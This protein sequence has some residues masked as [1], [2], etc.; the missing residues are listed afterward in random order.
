MLTL[1]AIIVERFGLVWTAYKARASG[2]DVMRCKQH[3]T[4]ACLD[5][6]IHPP[7]TFLS[8]PDVCLP[9]FLTI[10]DSTLKYFTQKATRTLPITQS[11]S[12]FGSRAR[13]ERIMLPSTNI[14]NVGCKARLAARRLGPARLR[15]KRKSLRTSVLY[16]HLNKLQWPM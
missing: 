16:S 2:S 7:P 1:E 3:A 14:G 5:L 6:S 12:T 4:S 15:M 9:Q 13:Q 8:L 11:P 10:F